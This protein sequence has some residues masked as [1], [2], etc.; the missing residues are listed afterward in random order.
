MSN[1]RCC[2]NCNF[3]KESGLI[4]SIGKCFITKEDK[5]VEEYCMGKEYFKL[6]DDSND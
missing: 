5:K 1:S 3:F 4:K 2:G 6:K